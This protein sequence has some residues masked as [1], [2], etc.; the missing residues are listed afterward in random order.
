MKDRGTVGVIAAFMIL[1][2]LLWGS[3]PKPNVELGGAGQA[4]PPQ[5]EK[6]EPT[7]KV[8][9]SASDD[10]KTYAIQ[11]VTD[12]DNSAGVTVWYR[13]GTVSDGDFSPLSPLLSFTEYSEGVKWVDSQV[14]KP[15]ITDVVQR[16]EV[17]QKVSSNEDVIVSL[18]PA[19]ATHG[20][21]ESPFPSGVS[22]VGF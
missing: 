6:V 4:P 12:P 16:Q 3:R 2:I 1:G 7:Y 18:S 8:A 9:Y 13:A 17:S 15:K 11:K 5:K 14:E 19:T 20:V 10:N 21:T 22:A